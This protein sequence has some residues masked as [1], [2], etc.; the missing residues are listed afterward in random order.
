MPEYHR[1]NSGK[2]MEPGKVIHDVA[3]N[4]GLQRDTYKLHHKQYRQTFA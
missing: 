4:A 1:L 3:V 2:T